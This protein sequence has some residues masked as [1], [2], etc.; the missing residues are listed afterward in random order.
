MKNIIY[1]RLFENENIKTAAL[2]FIRCQ[3]PTKGHMLLIDKM[4]MLSADSKFVYLSQS[5]D[6]ER[7]PLPYEKKR[8]YLQSFINEKYTDIEV[9]NSDAK[10]LFN[11]LNE[12][13]EKGYNYILFLVGSDREESMEKALQSFKGYCDKLSGYQLIS[14][15]EPRVE[16]K[17]INVLSNKN[18][19]LNLRYV[20]GTQMRNFV[21]NNQIDQFINQV[22]TSNIQLAKSLYND[23]KKGMEPP[24][25]PYTDKIYAPKAD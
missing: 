18:S 15:G 20:S 11:V 6:S 22:P 7:N 14:V 3:P 10:T 19:L 8:E 5:L 21:I 13:V 12:I 24:K 4:E 17:L 23:V 2:M 16:G 1:K 9:V 25:E